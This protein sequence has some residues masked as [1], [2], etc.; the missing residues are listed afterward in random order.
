M[1]QEDDGGPASFCCCKPVLN[2]REV[3]ELQHQKT[4]FGSSPCLE[5]VV[6]KV[7][8]GVGRA[9]ADLGAVVQWWC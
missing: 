2:T 7:L 3:M 6:L 5:D 8:G 1:G 4:Q 9:A